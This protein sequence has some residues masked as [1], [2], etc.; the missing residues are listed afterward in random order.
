MSTQ[1]LNGK[2]NYQI[3]GQDDAIPVVFIHGLMGFGGNWRKIVNLLGPRFKCLI[4]DQRGHGRSFKPAE[5]YAPEDYA[6]DLLH[7]SEQIGWSSFHLVGHSMGARNA[8]VFAYKYPEKLRSL[9]IEDMGPESNSQSH[10]YYE[11]LLNV[12]PTPFESRAAAKS[13]FENDFAKQMKFLDPVEVLGAFLNANLEEKPDGK[14]DW[15]FSKSG[16]LQTVKLGHVKDRWHEIASF[17]CKTLL[18]RGDKSSILSEAE[19]QKMLQIN[20]LFEGLEIANS[21]HWVHF[22]Q[23]QAFTESISKFIVDA[24]AAHKF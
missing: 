18:I 5:G 20:P 8:M 24:E 16:V 11:K 7:L 10:E 3:I 21:G 15:K 23:P 2:I 14:F 13:F 6:Q 1:D 22:D 19:F 12:I 4:Y 9:V 17:R